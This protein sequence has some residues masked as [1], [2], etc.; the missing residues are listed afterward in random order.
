MI[1]DIITISRNIRINILEVMHDPD[2]AM[3]EL[4]IETC[5]THG[6]IITTDQ[7]DKILHSMTLF[8]DSSKVKTIVEHPVATTLQDRKE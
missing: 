6:L 5:K 7:A 1:M 3:N 4:V 2:S 8:V